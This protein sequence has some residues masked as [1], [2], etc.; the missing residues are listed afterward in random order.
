M[1]SNRI[2][3]PLDRPKSIYTDLGRTLVTKPIKRPVKTTLCR[4]RSVRRA[5]V[6]HTGNGGKN[7]I[8]VYK[9]DRSDVKC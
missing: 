6:L 4:A 3:A 1:V 9:R 2:T 5:M 7:D 8:K